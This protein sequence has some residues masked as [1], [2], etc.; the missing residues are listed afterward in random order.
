MI[1]GCN[2]LA[3]FVCAKIVHPT[4]FRVKSCKERWEEIY[5]PPE[6][7]GKFR[8]GVVPATGS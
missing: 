5:D 8:K 6:R 2:K 3:L 1:N 4:G 7:A